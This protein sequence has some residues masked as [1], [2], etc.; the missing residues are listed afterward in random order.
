MK[1]FFALL[2][3]SLMA[4]SAMA[5]TPE[6]IFAR[7]GEAME[8]GEKEGTVM[9]MTMKVPILGS[10]PSKIYTLGDKSRTEV[11]AAGHTMTM[12]SDAG[13]VWAY[14]PDD[15]EIVINN[16]KG[17]DASDNGLEMMNDVTDGYDVTLEK[18]TDKIWYFTCKKRKDNPDKD[19]PKKMT[20]SVK[21]GSYILDRLQ[22]SM[23]GVTMTI[24]DVSFG[25]ISDE[26]VTFRAS[27]FP[28]AKITDK[29]DKE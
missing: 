8:R 12:W 5:Q 3:A 1:R 6:E 27:D 17:D 10:F 25:G 19:A 23:K 29:R 11:T 7:V 26:F 28:G 18:E 13:T 24:S 21:K 14:D 22:A 2:A 20:I 15:N 4:L 9:T 16:V